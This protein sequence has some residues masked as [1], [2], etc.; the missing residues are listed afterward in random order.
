MA[1]WT[2]VQSR[3]SVPLCQCAV[4]SGTEAKSGMAAL[5]SRKF[6]PA[7]PKDEDLDA[8]RRIFMARRFGIWEW[9][10]STGRLTVQPPSDGRLGSALYRVHADDADWFAAR[11][12]EVLDSGQK[13]I[14]LPVRLLVEDDAVAWFLA[15]GH[16]RN[17]DSAVS[18]FEGFLTEVMDPRS[19][20]QSPYA[21][22]VDSLVEKVAITDRHG[23]IV[24]TNQAWAASD[25]D[26]PVPGCRERVETNVLDALRA[27][28]RVAPSM[29]RVLAGLKAVL[30]GRAETFETEYF[31]ESDERWYEMR[32]SRLQHA[33]GGLVIVLNDITDR[34]QAERE[35]ALHR[36]E[37]GRTARAAALGQLSGAIAHELNQPLTAILAN[38]QAGLD[39][40]RH[41]VARKELLEILEDIEHDT[42]RA[43]EVIKRVR[44][45]LRID[46][47]SL[48]PIDLNEIVE[49]VLLL[50]RSDFVLRGVVVTKSLGAS[51]PWVYGDPIQLQQLVL[52]LVLNACDAMETIENKELRVTTCNRPI[53]GSRLIV[54][55][56]GRGFDASEREKVLQPFYTTKKHGLGLGLTIC[57]SIVQAHGGTLEL[58]NNEHGGARVTVDFPALDD[59]APPSSQGP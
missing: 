22:V 57:R 24:E 46:Q 8:I 26:L 54:D 5:H 58:G 17:D 34:R 52:N 21:A 20:L 2:L 4:K 33:E 32:V 56:R 51:L 59:T 55:D 3:P 44:R 7:P 40:G 23:E 27:A 53:G 39:A 35:R 45:L 13:Q 48:S 36:A 38:A 29:T 12:R 19:F 10:V 49:D 50:I 43:G 25:T 37:L 42:K 18:A 47:S 11:A 6:S 1:Y 15:T 14:A 31:V 41:G 9:S 28:A 30:Y 16:A